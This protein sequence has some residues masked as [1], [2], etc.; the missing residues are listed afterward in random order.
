MNIV[1]LFDYENIF[2][3]IVVVIIIVVL[4]KWV[5]ICVNGINFIWFEVDKIVIFLV[6]FKLL[7]YLVIIVDLIGYIFIIFFIRKFDVIIVRI[8]DVYIIIYFIERIVVMFFNGIYSNF[9]LIIKG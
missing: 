6:L 3:N 2:N 5:E 7:W 8:I 9:N 1:S 4:F